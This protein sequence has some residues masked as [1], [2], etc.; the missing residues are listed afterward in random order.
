[1]D[2]FFEQFRHGDSTLVRG[3]STLAQEAAL[4]YSWPGNVREL[5]NTLQRA[6]V[7]ATSDVLL[8]KNIPLGVA[9]RID[10][11]SSECSHYRAHGRII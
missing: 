11:S 6:V 4:A 10:A 3:F 5:E 1:M 8:P 9:A 7:F 2:L